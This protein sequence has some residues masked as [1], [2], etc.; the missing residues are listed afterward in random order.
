MHPK[1]IELAEF[2]RGLGPGVIDD[3]AERA[4][5]PTGPKYMILFTPR[6]GSSWLK[7]FIS[8]NGKLGSPG[9]YLNP[10]LVRNR[11]KEA[12]V[13]SFDGYL[14]AMMRTC[15]DPETGV[16]GAKASY[17][18]IEVMR[19]LTAFRDYFPPE[20]ATFFYLRREDAIE[21][22][23]SLYCAITSGEFHSR[24]VADGRPT[25]VSYDADGLIR[26][27]HHIVRAEIATEQFLAENVIRPMTLSYE[28]LF[29]VD[30]KT[31]LDFFMLPVLGEPA[32]ATPRLPTSHH[33]LPKDFTADWGERL[34][35]DRPKRLAALLQDRPPV[36][37]DL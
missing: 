5:T 12:G 24:D 37:S 3:P 4:E 20:Q 14:N 32:N 21:Q 25:E 35:A 6:S 31:L 19:G 10:K 8:L 1:A 29:A 27:L 15:R 9:E 17:F 33:K 16:F 18:Q 13:Q 36:R 22:A 26:W 2:F 7:A 34:A 30:P 11:A 23:I 28:R